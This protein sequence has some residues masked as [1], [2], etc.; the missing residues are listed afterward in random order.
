MTTGQNEVVG[1]TTLPADVRD[2]LAERAERTTRPVELDGSWT[3]PGGENAPLVDQ[4]STDRSRTVIFSTLTGEPHEILTIDRPRA[5]RLTR[6]DG[7]P[8]FWAPGMPGAQPVRNVGTLKCFLHPESAERELVDQAGYRNRFCNDADPSKQN[9]GDFQAVSHKEEHEKRKHPGA[10]AA[11]SR[12]KEDARRDEDRAL[13]KAQLAAME[14]IAE[15]AASAP[16]LSNKTTTP[17]E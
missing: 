9:R 16:A 5:L 15:R 8:S 7:K 4:T 11:V 1:Q 12:A 3:A 10:W 17:K 2:V 14:R 13:A 6:T